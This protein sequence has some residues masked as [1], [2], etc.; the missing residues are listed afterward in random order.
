MGQQGLERH[1]V[2]VAVY[3]R[4]VQR[5]RDA[6]IRMPSFAQLSEPITIPDGVQDRLASVDPDAPDPLNLFRVHWFNDADRRSGVAVPHHLVL[7]TSLTG[8]AAPMIVV[9]GEL[10]DDRRP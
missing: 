2:D 8:V 6:R 10:P 9:L 4:A 1:V 5:F 3:E 7:P